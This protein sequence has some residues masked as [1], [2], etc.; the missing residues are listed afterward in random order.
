MYQTIGKMKKIQVK[1]LAKRSKL[2][3]KKDVE[4]MALNY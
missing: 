4:F 2:V 3:E 1:R